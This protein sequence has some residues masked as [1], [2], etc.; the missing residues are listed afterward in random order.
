LYSALLPKINLSLIP[1]YTHNSRPAR[2]GDGIHP[3]GPRAAREET[4]T[5]WPRDPGTPQ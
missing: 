5:V 1:N 2:L 4:P 3:Q